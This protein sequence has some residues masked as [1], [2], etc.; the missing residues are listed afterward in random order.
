MIKAYSCALILLLSMTYDAA[1]CQVTLLSEN[2]NAV[3]VPS[4]WAL[5]N[6]SVGGNPDFG[7]LGPEAAAWTLRDDSYFYASAALRAVFRSNDASRFFL[8]N[9]D[10]QGEDTPVAPITNTIIQF[11]TITTLG[12]TST[13]LRFYH[14]FLSA[15]SPDAAFVEASLNGIAWTSVYTATAIDTFDIGAPDQFV[16]ETVN[17]DA[18]ANQPEVFLRFRYLASFGYYWAIDNVSVVAAGAI[19]PVQLLNFSGYRDGIKNKFLWA[20]SSEI[21]N[22]GFHVERSADAI[23]FSPIGF[24]NSLAVSGNSTRTIHYVYE[25]FNATG[26]KY[27]YRLRQQDIDGLFRLSHVVHINA[28]FSTNLL[29][30]SIYPLPVQS[31]LNIV[32]SSPVNDLLQVSVIDS[33]GRLVGHQKSTVTRGSNTLQVDAIKLTPGPYFLKV[34]STVSEAVSI[35]KFLKH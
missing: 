6:T 13:S 23:N 5:T 29:V 4:G 10:A 35:K 28:T 2:F 9:S 12:Y 19:V 27:Y 24:V 34:L 20:T 14:S 22:R 33:K 18:Y 25:D 7:G 8:S 3:S 32:I 31:V 21:N 16:L 15:G 17:L 26:V 1:H 30:S 11:P